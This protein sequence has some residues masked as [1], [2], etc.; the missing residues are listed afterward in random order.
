[1]GNMRPFIWNIYSQIHRNSNYSG[2]YQ[3]LGEGGN[4][5][6][7]NKDI[8]VGFTRWREF[9]ELV[10]QLCKYISHYWTL[11]FKKIKMGNF[12]LSV[13]CDNEKKNLNIQTQGS[14]IPNDRLKI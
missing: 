12:M 2:R 6:L 3:G 4:E 11:L 8:N 7:F 1:M 5:E 10:A 13:F 9:Q 14:N